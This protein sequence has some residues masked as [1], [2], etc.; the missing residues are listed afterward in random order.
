MESVKL[1]VT[2]VLEEGD[3]HNLFD[4]SLMNT[5]GLADILWLWHTGLL[6][7][8]ILLCFLQHHPLVSAIVDHS[9]KLLPNG[10]SIE[11]ISVE[12]GNV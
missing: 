9:A 3:V 5:L 1:L 4:T 10:A 8:T 6:N 11:D 2:A 7:D 12:G